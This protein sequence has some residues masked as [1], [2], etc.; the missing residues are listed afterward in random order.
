M[1]EIT[2]YGTALCACGYGFTPS[3]SSHKDCMSRHCT[4]SQNHPV[5]C[6]EHR[7]C[8]DPG[9][10]KVMNV[11]HMMPCFECEKFLMA[12]EG[13]KLDFVQPLQWQFRCT[14]ASGS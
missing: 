3:A 13:L 8:V 2:T 1:C 5:A 12:E 7:K 4:T 9:G 6:K 10:Q 11:L 14:K